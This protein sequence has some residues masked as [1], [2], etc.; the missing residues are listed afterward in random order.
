MRFLF[1][2]VSPYSYLAW[3]QIHAIAARHGRDVEPVP[4][5]FAGILKARDARGPAETPER[6][7][8]LVRDVQRIA[9]ALGVPIRPP[10]VH[11]FNPLLALRV[12]S[13]AP[14]RE[15][16]DALF[17]CAWVTGEGLTDRAVVER[18]AGR[19]AVA[20]AETDE[21]KQLL[22]RAT[23]EAIAAGVFGVP[24][25]LVD[26]EMFFGTDSLPHLERFLGGEDPVR[27]D[28]IAAWRTP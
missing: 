8:Y 2:F 19:E 14:R 9:H 24:T 6:R 18:A 3:T 11:P 25:I 13:R 21:A 27:A 7:A 22:R 10:P 20:A 28:F 15:L 17:T 1:D 4:V 23:D 5:L 16:I 12:A 26:R